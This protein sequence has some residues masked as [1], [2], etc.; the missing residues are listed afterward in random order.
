M[1]ETKG[2]H[3]NNIPLCRPD[4]LRRN[5]KLSATGREAQKTVI[6]AAAIAGGV[7][8]IP[9]AG[10]SG[11]VVVGGLL[12][13]LLRDLCR[14]YG[15]TFSDQQYKI[16]I[17]AILG[18]AH[19]DWISRYLAKLVRHYSSIPNSTAALLLR[20]A[21]AGLTVYYLGR[22]FLYHLESGVW[23]SNNKTSAA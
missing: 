6:K 1:A 2:L 4:Q 18:G 19:S 11:Q 8:L 13:K 22:L 10:L 12:L 21:T 5:R 20:P 17:A 16:L 23:L 3:E 15:A 7:G 14:L 9:L